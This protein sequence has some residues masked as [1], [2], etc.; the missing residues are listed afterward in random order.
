MSSGDAFYAF[1]GAVVLLGP[2]TASSVSAQTA[3]RR[4]YVKLVKAAAAYWRVARGSRAAYDCGWSPRM[5]VFWPGIRR[6]CVRVP[7]EKVPLLLPVVRSL[8]HLREAVRSTD[9]SPTGSGQGSLL[10][11]AM[12]L[13]SAVSL[14][15]AFFGAR[16]AL[17][18]AALRVSDVRVNDTPED[19]R[20]SYALS[21]DR[22]VRRWASGTHGGASVVEGRASDPSSGRFAVVA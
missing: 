16:R 10:G 12:V 18:V 3:V 22:S 4:S 21:E 6:S 5:G 17:E 20:F 15:V 19:V 8:A 1:F 7:V 14:S 2:S 13:R 11:D 9:L